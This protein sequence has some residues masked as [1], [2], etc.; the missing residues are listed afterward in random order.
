MWR[1]AEF[2]A[3]V[4]SHV[5]SALGDNLARVALAIVFFQRTGSALLAA[6]TFGVSYAPSLLGG[7][8]LSTFGDRFERR[9]VMVVC[10]VARAALVTG[11][12]GC[13]YLGW[14]PVAAIAFVL[15]AAFF[16]PAFDA[17]RAALIPQVV[18][19]DE[20]VAANV[21]TGMTL[22]GTQIVAYLAGA[23]AVTTVGGGGALLIDAGTF[24]LSAFALIVFVQR[25]PHVTTTTSSDP[26]GNAPR[27]GMV[28]M[29]RDGAREV[30]TRPVLRSLL[31]VSFLVVLGCIVPEGLAVVYASRHGLHGLAQGAFVAAVPIGT[32]LGG[33]TLA[34]FVDPTRRIR[35]I[36][37][38]ALA[39]PMALLLTAVPMPPA[40]VFVLWTI[41]GLLMSFLFPA[42]AAF[43]LH[44]PPAVRA[45]AMGLAQSALT[46]AQVLGLIGGGALATVLDVRYVVAVAGALTLAAIA[47]PLRHW[48][49]ELAVAHEGAPTPLLEADVR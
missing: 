27:A 6:A 7:P 43:V 38:L 48:P 13:V 9:R 25:R 3:L 5:F 44:T 46:G 31:S 21:V 37:P 11:A 47:W 42:N 30:W 33:I 12:A 26:R 4:A 17:S 8:L 16:S 22:Q 28:A 45:R 1:S 29:M 23:A 36:R 40:A 18:A 14:P 35:W 10:D 20:Y 34:R 39:T 32:T 24:V 2:R 41:A 49:A 15:T 19:T